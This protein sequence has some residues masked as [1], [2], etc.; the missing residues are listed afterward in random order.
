MYNTMPGVH[1][2]FDYGFEG[3]INLFETGTFSTHS[4]DLLLSHITEI[5]PENTKTWMI[6]D[7]YF[8]DPYDP[9]AFYMGTDMGYVR[10]IFYCGVIG[11]SI[12]LLYFINCTYVLCKRWKNLP[13][14]FL[15]LFVT[16]LVIW[17]KIPTDIFCFYALLLLA[18]SP[19]VSTEGI[20]NLQ[21]HQVSI[22]EK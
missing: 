20:D 11:L 7:G 4:S 16:Q 2:A 1:K 22:F 18:D 13:L 3:F 9:A 8:A 12:F 19:K 15:L 17:I 10:F 21:T 14:F 5:W 6:G